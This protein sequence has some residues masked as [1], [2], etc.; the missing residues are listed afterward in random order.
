MKNKKKL[1]ILS[2][3]GGILLMA[4]AVNG[5]RLLGDYTPKNWTTEQYEFEGAFNPMF[6][7]LEKKEK[8]FTKIETYSSS[9]TVIAS[10]GEKNHIV[11]F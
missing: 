10:N 9:V 2:I 5:F 8:D 4:Y 3:L 7:F 11:F 6:D 1:L